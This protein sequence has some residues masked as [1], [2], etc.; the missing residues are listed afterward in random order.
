MSGKQF[1]PPTISR[2]DLIAWDGNEG[3][4]VKAGPPGYVLQMVGGLPVFVPQSALTAIDHGQLLGLTPD[5]DHPQYTRRDILTTRGDMYVRDA[6][7]AVV[8]LAV[9]AAPSVLRGGTDPNYGAIDH[10]YIVNRTRSL[11]VPAANFL[12]AAGAAGIGNYGAAG[13]NFQAWAFDAAADEAINTFVYMPQDWVAGTNVT[14]LFLWAASTADGGN[15]LWLVRIT[16][17][18]Q[19]EPLNLALEGG[20]NVLSATVGIYVLVAQGMGAQAPGSG[21]ASNLLRFLVYRAAS[22]GTDTYP[23]DALFLGLLLLYDGDM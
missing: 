3:T 14:P 16:S 13:I 7:G 2:G 20:T 11:Y 17:V 18:A 21:T 19:S 22:D 1:W 15:V 9:G 8:R 6:A 10:S 5:D 4:R 23:A 12:V